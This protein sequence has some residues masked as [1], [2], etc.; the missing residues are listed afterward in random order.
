MDWGGG[1]IMRSVEVVGIDN[2]LNFTI[3]RVVDNVG[4]FKRHNI[5]GTGVYCLSGSGTTRIEYSGMVETNGNLN[6]VPTGIRIT[7][8]NGYAMTARYHTIS[9]PA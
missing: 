9:N 5:I 6:L 7:H 8:G 1:E 4:S 3:N 2:V